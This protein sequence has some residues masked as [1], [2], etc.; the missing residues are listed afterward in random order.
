MASEPTVIF[1]AFDR[2]NF[3]DLLIA[4]V[5]ARMLQR[6]ELLFAGL[7]A[8][9]PHG[10]GGPATVALA[11]IAAF[12][13]GRSVNV[14][15]A[16]GELLTCNAWEAAVML[17][18]PRRVPALVADEDTWLREGRAWALRHVGA[19]SLAPYVLSKSALPGVRV[20]HLSFNAVGGVDLDVRNAQLGADVLTALQSADAVSVRDGQTQALLAHRGIAARLIP[21][22]AT[23][24]AALFGTAICRHAANLALRDLRQ[25]L[26]H[27]YA[28]VQ[29]SADFGDDATLDTLATQLELAARGHYL[30]IVLFRAGAA[31]LHDDLAVYERLAARLRAV[32]VRV[33]VSLNVWDICALIA[34]SRIYC[35]SSLHGRIVAMAYALP[36]VNISH[37]DHLFEGNKHAAYVR[38]WEAAGLAGVVNPG[39]LADAVANALATDRESLREIASELAR[40]YRMEFE[41]AVTENRL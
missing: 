26:P 25:A 33:F 40:R 13:G 16:G 23:M 10:D 12:A 7:A 15:H 1:G 35:G 30:G 6:R 37:P 39:N 3:G 24:T 28:A 34:G 5:A 22:P 32:H 38:T 17:A 2:H 19:A 20:K 18:P 14:I 41:T 29:F 8:R 21:D 31:P 27:G 36:R 4:R 9:D 11:R